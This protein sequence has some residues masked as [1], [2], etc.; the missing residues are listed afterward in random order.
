MLESMGSKIV[1]Q[2]LAIEQ[3]HYF[4]QQKC[5]PIDW[6]FSMMYV[7]KQSCTCVKKLSIKLN[8]FC[9]YENTSMK[10]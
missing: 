6:N 4:M 9:D 5:N 3:E 1:G 2:D 10:V 7:Q 8:I